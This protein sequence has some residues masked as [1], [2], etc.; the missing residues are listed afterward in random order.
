M[1]NQNSSVLSNGKTKTC[2]DLHVH[3]GASNYV[4]SYATASIFEECSYFSELAKT[5]KIDKMYFA[6]TDHNTIGTINPKSD[7]QNYKT[8]T[9]LSFELYQQLLKEF[10]N[11]QPILGIEAN[12]NMLHVTDNVFKK[13]H[14]TAFADMSSEQK[15]KQWLNSKALN[16]YS[17]IKTFV[18]TDYK[19]TNEEVIEE[20]RRDLY[21]N[22]GIKIDPRTINRYNSKNLPA[23]E[24]RKQFIG[25]ILKDLKNHPLFIDCKDDDEVKSKL[26][27]LPMYT[28][29]KKLSLDFLKLRPSYGRFNTPE[30]NVENAFLQYQYMFSDTI[31]LED[32]KNK[33]DFSKSK[34]QIDHQFMQ[35]I[36]NRIS[37]NPNIVKNAK[38]ASIIT[39][40][41][42][43]S[44][45]HKI[46]K[47][48]DIIRKIYGHQKC[49]SHSITTNFDVEKFDEYLG[50]RLF[51]ARNK[52]NAEF[53]T[54]ISL[55]SIAQ[56][57]RNGNG[58]R[59]QIVDKFYMIAFDSLVRHNKKFSNY[60]PTLSEAKRVLNQ[61]IFQF[62]GESYSMADLVPPVA[63]P[64]EGNVYARFDF[65]EFYKIVKEAGGYVCLAHPN[66]A[67][68]Y[69]DNAKIHRNHF[70]GLDMTMLSGTQCKKLQ[71]YLRDNEYLD[72]DNSSLKY[73]M[74]FKL[75]L[76]NSMLAK[77][78]CKLDATEI[79][80][81]ILQNPVKTNNVL[82]FCA[83]HN[84][85]LSF[86]TDT[87]LSMLHDAYQKLS[88]GKIN[89]KEYENFEFV[90][91]KKKDN[92]PEKHIK[93]GYLKQLT[94]TISLGHGNKVKKFHFTTQVRH[95]SLLNKIFGKGMQKESDVLLSVE[96]TG[97]K[98]G[99]Y[100]KDFNALQDKGARAISRSLTYK[101][102][103]L[104]NRTYD[105]KDLMPT[106][107]L[108]VKEETL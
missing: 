100:D 1:E 12:C 25:E 53:G 14:V 27:S 36:A 49:N 38:Y 30:K 24:L 2:V 82:T 93:R 75:E 85:D 33:I 35:I 68:E 41:N 32:I 106:N 71:Q 9:K 62:E 76:I 70:Y 84:L 17:F 99:S 4:D 48:Y 37:G 60:A 92:S 105:S 102:S 80:K 44:I 3:G 8:T 28:M 10:P 29:D 51:T 18:Y 81:D 42:A 58:D 40:N 26:Y 56:I 46:Y 16:D 72:V 34:S 13:A 20:V 89:Q 43:Y 107:K 87:H 63:R 54:K 108:E 103:D 77:N 31:T 45:K 79:S 50:V 39:N 21:F 95:V 61:N 88:V 94:K 73:S 74:I 97:V 66:S 15:I 98:D 23:R 59:Q 69:A 90:A 47:Q 83:K 104:K 57:L 55:E 96:R 78:G 52:L 22:Y 86:G 101:K 11:V 67:F 64:V 91:Q 65:E 5:N 6:L 7:N 19:K